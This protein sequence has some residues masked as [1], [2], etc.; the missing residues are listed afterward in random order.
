[1]KKILLSLLIVLLILL[2]AFTFIKGWGFGSV[3]VL[4]FAD[5]KS[6]DE[7]LEREI[8]KAHT[9]A[10][11]DFKKELN[12]EN[13][14]IE[15]LEDAREQYKQLVGTDENGEINQNSQLERY[16][17]EYLWTQ[18]GNYA[19][20]EGVSLKIS[21]EKSFDAKNQANQTNA[22]T[23]DDTSSS[24]SS[25][26]SILSDMQAATVTSTST[27]AESTQD[28]LYDLTFEATGLYVSVADFIYDIENDSSLGFKIEDFNMAQHVDASENG[29][30]I[31][32]FTCKNIKIR[33]VT[34]TSAEQ[35]QDIRDEATKKAD[36]NTTN[37]T[38]SARSTNSTNTAK[39]NS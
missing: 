6:K 1:M 26:S 5:I 39:N 36:N 18:I 22:A 20:S 27:G 37:T 14:N 38:N 34:R 2:I 3:Q 23:N 15:K 21:V 17:M 4:S 33:Q 19:K 10:E 9:L 24:N 30:V 11:T 13:D 29:F 16:E 31:G 32:K 8:N 35:T 12:D 7:I 25:S 28:A